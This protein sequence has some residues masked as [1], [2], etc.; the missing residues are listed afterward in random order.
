MIAS[1]YLFVQNVQDNS[2]LNAFFEMA[3]PVI[4][5]MNTL[6]N[7]K[8][9]GSTMAALIKHKNLFRVLMKS[10]CQVFAD[11]S[12]AHFALKQTDIWLEI[13]ELSIFVIFNSYSQYKSFCEDLAK[14]DMTSCPNFTPCQIVP[15]DQKQKVVFLI[16]SLDANM[17]AKE[18]TSQKVISY[19]DNY[20]MKFFPCKTNPKIVIA[21]RPSFD[22]EITAQVIVDNKTDVNI[23]IDDFR[24]A[25]GAYLRETEKFISINDVGTEVI[26]GIKFTRFPIT[27][28]DKS[29]ILFMLKTSDKYSLSTHVVHVPHDRLVYITNNADKADMF[30]TNC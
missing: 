15:L 4:E 6:F 8:L 17:Q 27:H 13:I 3:L 12:S 18:E 14:V 23:V 25:L 29:N 16:T 22:K 10:G 24:R 21:D 1:T 7:G 5:K 28:E 9:S 30:L 2:E 11:F 20:F 26:N 19:C